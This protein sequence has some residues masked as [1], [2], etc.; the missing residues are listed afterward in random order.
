[1]PTFQQLRDMLPVGQSFAVIRKK[2]SIYVDKTRYLYNLATSDQ[3]WLLTRP[4]RFGKS[5]LVSAFEELFLHGVAPYDGHDSYFKDL[6]IEKLWTHSPWNDGPFYVLHLD[7]TVVL[8]GCKSAADFRENLND[9]IVQFASDTHLELKT[10]GT[11]K[12]SAFELLL[13]AVPNS[14]LVLLVDEYDAP[15][16]ALLETDNDAE[17]EAMTQVLRDFFMLIKAYSGKFRFT[18]ITGITRIKDSSIFS[19]A[20]NI[21]DISQRPEYGAICGITRE[22]LQRYFPEHLRYAAA[23]WLKLT[24]DQV[25]AQQVELLVEELAVWYDGYCFD[26]DFATQVFSIWSLLCFFGEEYTDFNSYW[27]DGSGQSKLLHKNIALLSWEDRFNIVFGDRVEVDVEDFLRPSKLESM[28]PEV[29]LFQSGYLTLKAPYR[30]AEAIDSFT[31]LLG[32]PNKEME[33]ALSR[34]YCLDFLP[35]KFGFRAFVEVL[36]AAIKE[37]D[38]AALQQCCNQVLQSVDYEHYPLTQ[39]SSVA[40]CLY[41]AISLALFVRVVVNNHESQGRADLLFDWQ[42]TTVVIELKYAHKLSETSGLLQQ[43]VAQ[44]LDRNYGDTLVQRPLLWRIAM[45]FCAEAREITDVQVV[46]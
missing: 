9:K 45:V 15:L 10:T 32:L 22:E 16:T 19:A 12:K 30:G 28:Q 38:A 37:Q 33:R 14:S 18:F 24:W 21:A 6:E 40:A 42:N 27:F 31:V 2:G 11:T 34:L 39:E 7:F 20:N 23:Q 44:V 36:C 41:I 17:S 8:I 1:M 29:L 4:R 35:K 5:T 25:T 13:E 43:A 3:P 46:S 26:R